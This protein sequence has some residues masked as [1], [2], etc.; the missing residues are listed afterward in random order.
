ML[1][2]IVNMW[3]DLPNSPVNATTGQLDKFWSHQAVKFHFTADLTGI[4]K[5]FPGPL[6]NLD[7][8]MHNRPVAKG[9]H[10]P[11]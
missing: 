11:R 4:G 8:T 10:A 5:S 1:L 6:F 7:D 9:G 2:R 3:N